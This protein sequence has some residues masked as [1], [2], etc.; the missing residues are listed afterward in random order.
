MKRLTSKVAAGAVLLLLVAA[1]LWVV[2]GRRGAP[3]GAAVVSPAGDR[4]IEIVQGSRKTEL[5][6]VAY[7]GNLR[8]LVATLSEGETAR[9]VSWS[10]D[11]RLVAFES[12]DLEGHSPMTTTHVWVVEAGSGAL[13]EVK[14][15]PPNERFSTYFEGWVDK[16][17]LRLRATL[18]ERPED[19]YFL[20]S[21]AAGEVRGPA[22]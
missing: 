2:L 13:R 14:L 5:W 11:G 4:G 1:A 15:P 10:P 8:R 18:L 22:G 6:L 17:T 3:D 19:L 9:N 12:F 20:Y 7:P 16:E 21:C